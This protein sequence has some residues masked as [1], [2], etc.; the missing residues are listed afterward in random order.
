MSY[1]QQSKQ[2]FQIMHWNAQGITSPSAIVELEQFVNEKEIDIF[3]I[4]ETFLNPPHKFNMNN[5]KIYR[6]DRLSHGGGV[7]IGIKRNIPHQRI[8]KFATKTIENVSIE[9]NVNN[10]PLRI[11]SAY[12]PKFTN[13]FYNDLEIITTT[14][15]DFFIFGDFNAHHTNWHCH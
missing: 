10:L 6:E 9:I 2:E 12:C 11:T 8:T 1:N 4:N 13:H 15:T 5:Y 14:G 3:L 7:M